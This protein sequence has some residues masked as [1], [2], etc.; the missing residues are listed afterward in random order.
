MTATLPEAL[1]DP[2]V[3]QDKE[4]RM[5]DQACQERKEML[6]LREMLVILVLSDTKE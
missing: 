3:I 1:W 5:E 2:L 4:E 6:V